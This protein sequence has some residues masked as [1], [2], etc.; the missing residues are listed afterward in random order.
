MTIAKVFMASVMA[1][2]EI[3]LCGNCRKLLFGGGK[4]HGIVALERPK[5]CPHCGAEIDIQ[6]KTLSEKEILAY[7]DTD[8][9]EAQLKIPI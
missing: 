4:T 7:A 9:P 8:V 6:L 1:F 3:L 5:F 2:V